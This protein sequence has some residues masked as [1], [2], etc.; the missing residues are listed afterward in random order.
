MIHT[1]GPHHIDTTE[2]GRSSADVQTTSI[3][4]MLS[5]VPFGLVSVNRFLS[6]PVITT[7]KSLQLGINS[8]SG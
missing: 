4:P 3:A 6:K 2:G 1:T 8:S 5:T 7:L